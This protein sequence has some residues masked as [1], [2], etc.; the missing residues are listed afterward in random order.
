LLFKEIANTKK[1]K[2][3]LQVGNVVLDKE[4]DLLGLNISTQ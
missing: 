4:K 1:T 3:Y 2:D